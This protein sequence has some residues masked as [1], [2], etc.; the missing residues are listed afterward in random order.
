MS[1]SPVWQRQHRGFRFPARRVLPFSGSGCWC[2]PSK[3]SIPPGIPEDPRKVEII[4]EK[5]D[6]FDFRWRQKMTEI[7][8]RNVKNVCSSSRLPGAC[9]FSADC[10]EIPE[11]E[12]SSAGEEA[13]GAETA[14]C[15]DEPGS[16]P[17]AGF[18]RI[19]QK[20]PVQPQSGR[21]SRIPVLEG[22]AFFLPDK[23][24]KGDSGRNAFPGGVGERGVPAS[25][26]ISAPGRYRFPCR[27]KIC[28][29]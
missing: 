4:I 19:Q 8:L 22:F 5:H 18:Q 10:P 20:Q 24:Q 26:S 6:A 13:D 2:F 23:R 29:R 11:L 27:K 1:W 7:R 14:G 15:G 16:V 9:F 3:H 28:H 17:S 21:K 25:P 12:R